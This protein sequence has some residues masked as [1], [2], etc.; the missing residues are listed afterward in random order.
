MVKTTFSGEKEAEKLRRKNMGLRELFSGWK[1]EKKVLKGEATKDKT[2]C[3]ENSFTSEDEAV[4]EFNRTVEKLF[5]VNTWSNL[6]GITSTFTLFNRYGTEKQQKQ[7]EVGDYIKILLPGPTPENWVMVTNITNEQ[8]LSEFTVSPSK[9]PTDKNEGQK[10]IEHFF[11]EEATSTFRVEL[12]GKTI[13]ACEL[14]KN[15]GINN[16]RKA[17]DR[18]LIN[19]ILAEGGWAAFQK[20]QWKKLTDYLVHKTEVKPSENSK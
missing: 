10:E 13:K 17:G 20:T 11:I 15:E 12:S 6:P 1:K 2:Y 14:G 4:R 9:D 3:S 7:P 18:E 8:H 19:T 5:D 16:N